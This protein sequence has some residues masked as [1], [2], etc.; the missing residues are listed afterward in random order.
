M[1]TGGLQ[2]E[3]TLRT[4]VILMII[5]E[6]QREA[7]LDQAHVPYE[8]RS[9]SLG[10]KAHL[11]PPQTF[12]RF[13]RYLSEGNGIIVVTGGTQFERWHVAASAWSNV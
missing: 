12:D 1:Q 10:S 13:K 3:F 6:E 2:E 5:D 9:L 8:Y 4:G 7:A 11:L